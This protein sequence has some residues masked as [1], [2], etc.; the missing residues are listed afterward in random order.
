M[1][2]RPVKSRTTKSY[3]RDVEVLAR[4][5]TA[6]RFDVRLELENRNETCNM[7]ALLQARLAELAEAVGDTVEEDDAAEGS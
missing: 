6:V 4:L 1:A 7:I 2:G 5:S 3:R